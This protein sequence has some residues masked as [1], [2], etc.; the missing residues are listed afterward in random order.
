MSSIPDIEKLWIAY[1]KKQ[2]PDVTFI[3]HLNMNNE[4]FII[5]KVKNYLSEDKKGRDEVLFSRNGITTPT[6][7][8]DWEYI[9]K[10][11][12]EKSYETKGSV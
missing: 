5:V 4:S 7:S 1:I 8:S 3:S 2:L 12:K 9:Y 11:L 6:T 10:V